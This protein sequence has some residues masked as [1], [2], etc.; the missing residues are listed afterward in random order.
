MRFS[1][2]DGKWTL[3]PGAH[4]SSPRSS[5]RSSNMRRATFILMCAIG[6]VIT[7]E[8]A[9]ACTC[10]GPA[11]PAE[12]LKRSAAVFRGRVTEISRPFLDRLGLTKTGGHRVE[13]EVLKRWKGASSRSAAI[14]TRLTGEAC[15]FPFEKNKE[16]LV[17][18]VTE[19]SDIQSGI[20]TG[21]KNIADAEQEMKELDRLFVAPQKWGTV[22]RR[23]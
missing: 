14:V 13:F 12:G 6:C 5:C 2:L 3:S 7:A 15:G 11:T 21:T 22:L 1:C 20:C 17:Y 18:A 8:P 4:R 19:P 10:S 23:H 9:Q 16:Y